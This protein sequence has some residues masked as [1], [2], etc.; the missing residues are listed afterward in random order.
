MRNVFFL[1]GIL[2][3]LVLC[4]VNTKAQGSCADGS[5]QWSDVVTIFQNNGCNTATCHGGAAGGLDLTTF[6]GF[7]TGGTKCGTEIQSGTTLVDIIQVGGVVCANGTVTNAMNNN[8]GN[9]MS[10][11]DIATIQA[12]IDEGSFEFC[13]GTPLDDGVCVTPSTIGSLADPGQTT[14]CSDGSDAVT[15]ALP[16]A[17]LPDVQ[18]VVEINGVISTI[19]DDGSFDTSTLMDGDEICYTAFTFDLAAINTLLTTASQLCPILDCDNTFGIM[20]VNQAID[21]LVNGVNDGMPGLNDLQEA[22]DFAGS[23]GNPIGSVQTAGATLDALNAQIGALLGNVCYASSAAVCLT[24]VDCGPTTCPLVILNDNNLPTLPP[25][26]CA[27]EL[28]SLCFDVS[29]DEATFDPTLVQFNYNLTI[30]GAPSTV[31]LNTSYLSGGG[32][33]PAA[34]GQLCFEAIVPAGTNPC[35]P[36]ELSLEIMS[37]FYNDPGCPD[38][39]VAYDLNI[40]TPIA[41]MQTGDNLNDLIP[42]LTIGGL[43]PILVQIFPNPNWTANVTQTPAC[44]GTTLG[45]IEIIAADGATVCE[46]LTNV[47]TAGMDGCP[48]SDAILPETLYENYT[49]FTD[50]DGMEQPNPCAVSITIPEQTIACQDQCIICPTVVSAEQEPSV[51]PDAGTI[52]FCVTFDVVLDA[53]TVVTIEGIS[54]DGS[55]GG[56][57]ICIDV[58]FTPPVDPCNGAAIDFVATAICDGN[59]LLAGSI[60]L[61][62]QILPITDAACGGIAG[63]TDAAACNYNPNA[64]CDDP[65]NPCLPAP[66]CN[67]DPCAG[68]VEIVDPADAC[69]CIID[70]PQ[71]FGCTDLSACNYEPTANCDDGSC[72]PAPI[73]NTDPCAGD[74]EIV[75]P[76]DACSCIIDQVQVLGCTDP[77]ATNYNMN[78][79]CDDGSCIVEMC[80]DP[81]APNFGAAEAC[82][83]YNMTCN[84]DCTMGDLEIWDATTCSCIV[85]VPTVLGCTDPVAC[86]YNA[87]ATCEDG[88]CLQAPV[89]N[90]DPCVGDTE[91][92]DPAD[93]CSC[94]IDQ[95]QVLGCTDIGATNYDAAANCDDG[96]CMFEMCADPCAPNFGAAEACEPY[97]M[98]C[99]DD[100]TAG[101]F[102]GTWDPSTCTCIN[103][104]TPVN[105]CTDSTATN[106]DAAANCDDGSCMFAMCDDPC[107]PNFGAAEAC[108]PYNM[109]CN[110]DCT[111]GA[112]GGT[113][114][115]TTCTCINETTPVNGCTD[116]TASN[117]DPSANC[118]DG[119]CIFIMCDDPC[120]PNFG[121]AEA[122]EPYN[123]TCNDDCT[124]GAFG[125]TWD[126]TTCACINET[127]PINGCTDSMA[128]NY[129]PAANCDDGSCFTVCE[130]AI[131]GGIV[132]PDD[133]CDVAGLEVM[134]MAPDGTSISVTTA[135]DGSFTV[136][137]GPFPCGTYTATITDANVP[138]CYTETGD[139]GPIQFVVDGT[140][141]GD[142][143][144][145]FFANP[146]VPTLSQWGLMI[147]VLLLMT[148]GA[149]KISG[150]TINLNLYP[151]K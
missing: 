72:Q 141:S 19:S 23:F 109:T 134:I 120:A 7:N 91:I 125:G 12:Y 70:Q 81:C 75:D 136:P 123:M 132:V 85:D 27:D 71:V 21:D 100:C 38:N 114:D 133:G 45:I 116:S 32:I 24:V 55:G 51:C 140:G 46:T 147:L 95:A 118:E 139:I 2:S 107:A 56:M 41:V 65:A 63:C 129:D 44:D 150:N 10:A 84:T 104:T 18:I 113:W 101:A 42:L 80:T 47:G 28:L 127:T 106:Y 69:S 31:T 15:F 9:T 144:P 110:D 35:A 105:G 73:C 5:Y 108:E 62:T 36:Y 124:A 149:L 88:S 17:S 115:A 14:L 8:T 97:N 83:P 6:D 143:G 92:V 87:N 79:N 40:T 3:T 96:S 39:F 33:D 112:F 49:T 103:E 138:A 34:T 126:T 26:V 121:T 11:A 4:N 68:D 142:D 131:V 111:A 1:L 148:F 59:D 22:L 43:N 94:I 37:V 135:A 53:N 93:A 78:A 66:T 64:V 13:P 128:T 82:E 54:V 137:G 90:T 61:G 58:P 67:T 60:W 20:G 48:V 102:G 76:A 50:A 145:F 98:T 52:Q 25:A 146:A 130:E 122:C 117:Y 86:N 99:N 57:Q 29:V 89:C 77:S 74:I 119:S 151:K 16:T 30:D